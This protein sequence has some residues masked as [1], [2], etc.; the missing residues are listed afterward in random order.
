MSKKVKYR[1]PPMRHGNFRSRG[2]RWGW[3]KADAQLLRFG[4]PLC[5]KEITRAMLTKTASE[6]ADLDDVLNV[7]LARTSGA[8]LVSIPKLDLEISKDAHRFEDLVRQIN[9]TILNSL[10]AQTKEA[11][12]QVEQEPAARARVNHQPFSN[13]PS[14]RNPRGFPATLPTTS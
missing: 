9:Q 6:I 10:V 1:V 11:E 8:F 12:D 2:F 3:H 4:N 14:R 7:D 13:D 5:R